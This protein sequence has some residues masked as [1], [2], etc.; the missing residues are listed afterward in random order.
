M[1]LCSYCA[2]RRATTR[3][4]VPPQC[5]FS[6]PRPNN[7]ITVP[8]CSTCHSPTSPDDEYFKFV[9]CSRVDT[10]EHPEAKKAWQGVLRAMALPAKRGMRRAVHSS[11]VPLDIETP[12]G[13]YLGSS[14]GFVVDNR[15]IRRVI[16]RVIVGLFAHQAKRPLPPTHVA[17]AV[18]FSG[19]TK[20][21]YEQTPR[22]AEQVAAV[23]WSPGRQ[24]RGDTFMYAYHFDEHDRDLSAWLLV[25]YGAF[26]FFGVTQLGAR[27]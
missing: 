17:N 25:F 23:P 19:L 11:L 9:L 3:D 5:V 22:L 27:A 15:R 2:L 13:V 18:W 1:A 10:H 8:A 26:A 16:T 12:G 6:P 24:I 7:L 21:A 20:A 4:H 14:G